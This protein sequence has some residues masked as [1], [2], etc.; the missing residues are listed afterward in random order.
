MNTFTTSSPDDDYDDDDD[1]DNSSS[2]E[3]ILT[4]LHMNISL[5]KL[6]FSFK[7]CVN[8]A[9]PETKTLISVSKEAPTTFAFRAS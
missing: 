1:N 3:Q 9:S 8:S 5:R 4:E 7:N 6:T 2:L